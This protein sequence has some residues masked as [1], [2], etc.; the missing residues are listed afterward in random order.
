MKSRPAGAASQGDGSRVPVQSNSCSQSSFVTPHEITAGMQAVA[1]LRRGPEHAAAARRERPLV[2]VGGVPVDAERLDV[3]RRSR[4]GACAP[5]T[6]TGT[7][8]ARQAAASAASGSTSAVSDVT[9]S[10]RASRVRGVI[11]RSSASTYASGLV[12]GKGHEKISTDA[13][14]WRAMKA[15]RADDAAVGLVGHQDLVARARARSS[16]ARR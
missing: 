13:P 4:P 12:A 11:A 3:E 6:S 8:R 16:A 1:P 9:W 7:P 14:R 2:Q 5:S 15:R 10:I